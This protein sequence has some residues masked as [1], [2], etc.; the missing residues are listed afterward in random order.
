MI[1]FIGNKEL[2]DNNDSYIQCSIDDCY[3]YFKNIDE[4]QVD[5]ETEGEFNFENRILTLQLGDYDNQ[6]VI[7]VNSVNNLDILKP[8]IE[9]E[10]KC[11]VLQ[12]AAFDYKFIKHCLNWLMTNIYDTFIAECIITNG[13]K[14]RGLG[15]DAISRKY[16][17]I[18]VS[19][20]IRGKINKLG[21]TTD[22]IIYAANDVK[23]L[24]KIKELQLIKLEEDNLLDVLDLENK[25]IPILANMSMEGLILDIDTWKTLAIKS[26]GNTREL[27]NKLDEI[28][29]DIPELNTYYLVKQLDLFDSNFVKESTIEW[30]SPAQALRVFKKMKIDTNSASEKDIAKFQTKYPLVKTYIDYKKQQKLASTYGMEFI[31]NTNRVTGRIHYDIWQILDSHRISTQNPNVQN[32]PSKNNDYLNCFIAPDNY[33]IVGADISG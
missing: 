7:D 5:T 11:K 31:N 2:I 19:K 1:Y 22:V 4:F 32:I 26:E 20:E 33:S 15:L 12:N 8:L 13:I 27:F 30:N 16:L 29:K 28:G 24:S 3:D 14:G 10:D 17:N 18:G 9:S 21:L 6:F 25:I 23:Y